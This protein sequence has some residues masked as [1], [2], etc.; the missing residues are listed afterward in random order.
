MLKLRDIP[1]TG[2]KAIS[3]IE[4]R[5]G[6]T[7]DEL[8]MFPQHF[9]IETVNTCN[10]RCIMCGIDFDKKAKAIIDKDLF[11]K[12]TLE[13]SQHRDHVKKV[14]L[15]LDGEPLMDKKL[16]EKIRRMK[17]AGV[18][19]VNIATN[20][21]LLHEKWGKALIDAGLD[22]IYITIDS[23]KKDI[24]E[25]IRVG[26]DFDAVYQNTIDLIALRDKMKSDLVIR[27]NMVLQE[28]NKDEEP[29]FQEHFQKLVSAQDQVTVRK[30][31]NWASR[32]DVGN[33]GDEVD[34]NGY[35]CIALWG[36]CV[37]HVNGDIPLCCMDTET[38]HN[39]GNVREQ[40]IK[41]IWI[42]KIM[43]D[44]K[45]MHVDSRRKEIS[46]CDGCTVWRD[47]THV[48]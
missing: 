25:K 46:M 7:I 39:L 48:S 4:S 41:D 36:T 15:Y 26:L 5:M 24:F 43:A 29:A 45:K 34:V 8:N 42:G 35:P 19:I 30:S 40:S 32:V 10:A 2:D 47:N 13:I 18:K 17:A 28:L 23:L 3:Y 21:S 1:I 31:H 37:I 6:G 44:F 11:E 27:V 14:S 33:W 22:E 16:P 9:L 12:I 20:A 38:C